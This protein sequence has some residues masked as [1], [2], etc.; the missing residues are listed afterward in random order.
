[1]N[2]D[3]QMAT[4]NL[5]YNKY[6]QLNPILRFE[7]L[8]LVSISGNFCA[9]AGNDKIME[10]WRYDI[11]PSLSTFES[12]ESV[13]SANGSCNNLLCIELLKLTRVGK[14]FTSIY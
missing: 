13:K 14:S 2:Y 11:S 7:N 5:T 9:A 10:M 1:M 12:V 4:I 8:I 6:F 3:Q